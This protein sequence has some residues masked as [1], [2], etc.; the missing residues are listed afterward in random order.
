MPRPDYAY[1]QF[2]QLDP[3]YVTERHLRLEPV[4]QQ[5]RGQMDMLFRDWEEQREPRAFGPPG[6]RR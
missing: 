4:R 2:R 3:K 5:D 6:K 1:K